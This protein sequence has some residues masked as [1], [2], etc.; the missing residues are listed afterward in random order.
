MPQFMMSITQVLH[1]V[2]RQYRVAPSIEIPRFAAWLMAFCSAWTVGRNAALFF[3]LHEE[4]S[5]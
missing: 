4:L 2:I 5:S 1:G 3:H